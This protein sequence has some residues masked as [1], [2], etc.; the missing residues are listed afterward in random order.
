LKVDKDDLQTVIQGNI[1]G[2]R[3]AKYV[4][5][6][7]DL[8]YHG[9]TKKFDMP[10]TISIEHILPQTPNDNS[11]WKRDFTDE[12]RENWTNKL[13]NLVLI[14]RRKNSSQSNRD[15]SDKKERY[16]KNNIELFSN[17]IRIYENYS[18]WTVQDL[19]KNHEDVLNKLLK[20]GF[21]L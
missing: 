5:L 17:S 14:S 7:L 12:E 6:K 19:K 15:Y 21:G 13:G 2:K 1:Y 20:Y 3:A 4:L 9:H 10:D 18:T 8:L 11:Q 16:F